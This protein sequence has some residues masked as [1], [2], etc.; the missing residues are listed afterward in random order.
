MAMKKIS[1]HGIMVKN[2]VI[3]YPLMTVMSRQIFNE[4]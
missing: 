3:I 4:F 1:W 2:W